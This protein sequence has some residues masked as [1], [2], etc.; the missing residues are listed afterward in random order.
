MDMGVSAAPIICTTAPGTAP[1]LTRR[2]HVDL[3]R[4][5]SAICR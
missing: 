5:S 1:R 2:M 4:V 3:G